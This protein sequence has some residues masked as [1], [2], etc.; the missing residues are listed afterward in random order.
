MR[1]NVLF[2]YIHYMI[3][4]VLFIAVRSVHITICNHN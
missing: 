2:D 4:F 1:A 3:L